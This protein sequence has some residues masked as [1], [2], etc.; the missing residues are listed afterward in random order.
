MPEVL[1]R[2]DANTRRKAVDILA[3]QLRRPDC[4][5]QLVA[6]IGLSRFG[7]EGKAS[8][9]ILTDRFR[10]GDVASRL[11]DLYLLG[12]TGPA[13]SRSVPAIVRE[14]TSPDAEK[15]VMFFV[16]PFMLS[17]KPGIGMNSNGFWI[18]RKTIQLPS[19]LCSLGADVLGRIGPEGE[20]QAVEILV[21]VDTWRRRI[22]AREQ[23]PRWAG[24]ARGR[25]GDPDVARLGGAEGACPSRG[26]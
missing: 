19:D 3:G 4:L 24:S 11:W 7:K 17:K 13:A 2:L 5:G 16:N 1:A 10:E 9:T 8:A 14:M 21:G 20:R 15:S 6:A 22:V 26:E 12:R 25:H 18:P 23:R